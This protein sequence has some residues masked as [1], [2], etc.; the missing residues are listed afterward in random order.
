MDVGELHIL[1]NR[2]YTS[3]TKEYN[4]FVSDLQR[5]LFTAEQVFD[6]T[7]HCSDTYS[8]HYVQF[9]MHHVIVAQPML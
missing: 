6:I 1:N 4:L 7:I 2:N 3:A 9:L 8:N 5:T